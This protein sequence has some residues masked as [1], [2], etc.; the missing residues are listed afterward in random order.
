MEKS[1]LKAAFD[2]L[3]ERVY[4]IDGTISLIKLLR[5]SGMTCEEIR[6]T[7]WIPPDFDFTDLD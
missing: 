6:E 2:A 5:K 7:G 4:Y 3:C 1:H